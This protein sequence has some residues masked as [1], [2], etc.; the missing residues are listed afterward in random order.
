MTLRKFEQGQLLIQENEITDSV[1]FIRS[2]SAVVYKS[3]LVPSDP[4][5]PYAP[6]M[7]K[8]LELDRL[9]KGDVVNQGL[10]VDRETFGRSKV[11]VQVQTPSLEFGAI[12]A[13][14]EWIQLAY[15]KQGAVDWMPAYLRYT[16]EDLM[17]AYWMS[18][19]LKRF[20]RLKARILPYT[21]SV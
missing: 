18:V 5:D 4:R 9:G 20:E 16:R 7:R 13:Y 10:L 8:Q 21:S 17:R 12:L 3:L 11:S 6:L 15:F 1:Y 2:G 14:G 19:Q